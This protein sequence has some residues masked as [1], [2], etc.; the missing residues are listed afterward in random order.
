[1]EVRRA[2]AE[3]REATARVAA[4]RVREEAEAAEGQ[5]RAR[6]EE[7]D[8][9]RAWLNQWEAREGRKMKRRDL[10]GDRELAEKYRR[11]QE[12]KS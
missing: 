6:D 7:R 5:K 8:A 1:M 10:E 9:L 4:K 3:Q 11:Y 12:L 2:A